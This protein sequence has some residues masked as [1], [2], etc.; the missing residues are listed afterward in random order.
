MCLSNLKSKIQQARNL[1]RCALKAGKTSTRKTENLAHLADL[2]AE[3]G[4][5]K[6]SKL[7]HLW[8]VFYR[9]YP[10]LFAFSHP[11][12]SLAICIFG[13]R[14]TILGYVLLP[15]TFFCLAYSL[16]LSTSCQACFNLLLQPS[17]L[18]LLSIRQ[19]GIL[20]GLP[21]EHIVQATTTLPL[22]PGLLPIALLLHR[23]SRDRAHPRLSWAQHLVVSGLEIQTVL[24]KWKIQMFIHWIP[25]IHIFIFNWL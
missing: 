16:C 11:F 13:L 6:K 23:H 20:Q 24:S 17:P 5:R 7:G 18:R 14:P 15:S 4:M 10:P 22:L 9:L 12:K 1:R 2:H 25:N 21:P 19:L 3:S 8:I